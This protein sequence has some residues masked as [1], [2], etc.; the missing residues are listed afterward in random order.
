[1]STEATGKILNGQPLSEI[2]YQL[3]KL[4]KQPN[5]ALSLS[6]AQYLHEYVLN[7]LSLLKS[8]E[9]SNS[10]TFQ[11]A[12]QLK[13]K[14]QKAIA[15]QSLLSIEK[16]NLLT[17]FFLN[18]KSPKIQK[19]ALAFQNEE[20][21]VVKL[22]ISNKDSQELDR[23][24]KDFDK[25]L[26]KIVFSEP[27]KTASTPEAADSL[28]LPTLPNEIIELCL[29]FCPV[30]HW[31]EQRLLSKPIKALTEVRILHYYQPLFNGKLRSMQELFEARVAIKNLVDNQVFMHTVYLPSPDIEVTQKTLSKCGTNKFI[32]LETN[33]LDPFATYKIPVIRVWDLS[34]NLC[35]IRR[36]RVRLIAAND[37]LLFVEEGSGYC[38]WDLQEK[39]KE[40]KLSEYYQ[41]LFSK[42]D[43]SLHRFPN[44]TIAVVKLS[45][46]E[47]LQQQPKVLLIDPKQQNIEILPIEIDGDVHVQVN[48]PYILIRSKKP[49]NT[50]LTIWNLCSS[51]QKLSD[52]CLYNDKE[53]MIATSDGFFIIGS[54]DTSFR[55][56]SLHEQNPDRRLI[57][58]FNPAESFKH[59]PDTTFLSS[60][61]MVICCYKSSDTIRYAIVS[62]SRVKNVKIQITSGLL[63]SKIKG[64]YEDPLYPG[65]IYAKGENE[66]FCIDGFNYKQPIFHKKFLLLGPLSNHRD[67]L[68]VQDGKISIRDVWDTSVRMETLTE[69]E[70]STLSNQFF[71]ISFEQA[72]Q[73]LAKLPENT[74]KTI[75]SIYEPKSAFRS[76]SFTQPKQAQSFEHLVDKCKEYLSLF[77]QIDVKEKTMIN[78]ITYS[79]LNGC[80]DQNMKMFSRLSSIDK[81]K[82]FSI[83]HK[84]CNSYKE[85]SREKSIEIFLDLKKT[86]CATNT[87]R[88]RA[89][90]LSMNDNFPL[91]T[92]LLR[93][94]SA[95][96]MND[97]Q[98]VNN[99]LDLLPPQQ[100]FH[101][102][103][104]L[105]FFKGMQTFTKKGKVMPKLFPKDYY[106]TAIS[107][108]DRLIIHGETF[109]SLEEK[110]QLQQLANC[111]KNSGT[112]Q[113]DEIIKKLH[114]DIVS[115]I[116]HAVGYREGQL[117]DKREELGL[118]K[119]RE[120]DPK[121]QVALHGLLEILEDFSENR[122]LYQFFK[123]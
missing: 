59:L 89:V 63:P 90:F 105:A 2:H 78:E 6:D 55:F 110:T 31:F 57:Y 106:L 93:L 112:S 68:D 16:I 56:Y 8:P 10:E 108:I 43:F 111:L 7:V 104:G 102:D 25:A 46:S 85:I 79:L 13:T 29:S 98:E 69:K 41:G 99:L 33:E 5:D 114:P 92:L 91:V 76:K 81:L 107:V 14:Y 117:P 28:K 39:G 23:F 83:F 22:P 103:N 38:L 122:F 101:F 87:M 53:S 96:K 113:F 65:L 20:A 30:N 9:L 120:H 100:R 84:L 66:T 18:N 77:P 72:Q 24:Q 44:N 26:T 73:L 74:S 54:K 75:L 45:T 50:E 32:T 15:T 19:D 82:V 123:I 47:Q 36:E 116:S 48:E 49:S 88:G 12:T 1:M 86:D 11:L 62:I 80:T 67:S 60:S 64:F 42:D 61:G 17:P 34:V 52:V 35:I 115:L 97:E 27:A 51:K 58:T 70:K 4:D 40:Y 37:G 94:S 71:S 119:I 109:V 121:V 3:T 118:K 21:E 95:L